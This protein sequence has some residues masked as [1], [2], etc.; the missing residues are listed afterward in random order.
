LISQRRLPEQPAFFLWGVKLTKRRIAC[1]VDG[2]NLYHALAELDYHPRTKKRLNQKNHFKWL[3]IKSMVSAFITPSN[4]EITD[5]Y[6]F[7]AFAT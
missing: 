1:F 7:S 5:V 4:E 2:F 3:D 6:Y